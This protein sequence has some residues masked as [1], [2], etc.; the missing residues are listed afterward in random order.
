M[1]SIVSQLKSL[2]S[3]MP[4]T[5]VR[6]QGY[7]EKVK[8]LCLEL[9]RITSVKEASSLS[10]VSAGSIYSWIRSGNHLVPT[11]LPSIPV[12]CEL[13]R[14]LVLKEVKVTQESLSGGS[15]I[16]IRSAGG[17]TVQVP[18]DTRVL[19]MVLDRI[20]GASI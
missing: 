2:L 6:G 16:T 10:G 8:K 11:N 17:V 4:Q 5:R 3:E 13:E 20:I 1:K 19:T 12:E 18:A 14:P 7:P 9:A 15:E